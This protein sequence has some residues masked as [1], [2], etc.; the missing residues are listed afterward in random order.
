MNSARCAEHKVTDH[1]RTFE[2]GISFGPEPPDWACFMPG[3]MHRG[4]VTPRAFAQLRSMI[5]ASAGSY[6]DDIEEAL[7][8]ARIVA[9]EKVKLAGGQI[10]FPVV[11]DAG[12]IAAASRALR[13]RYECKA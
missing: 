12:D 7:H 10:K 9:G 1:A 8:A 5:V 4:A 2:F 6:E 3:G 11:V 13:A